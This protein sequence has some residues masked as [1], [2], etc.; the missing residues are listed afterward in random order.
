MVCNIIKVFLS[1]KWDSSK[2]GFFSTSLLPSLPSLCSKVKETQYKGALD[3]WDYFK[4]GSHELWYYN[5]A[6]A[7]ELRTNN[8]DGSYE[9]WNC[10]HELGTFNTEGSIKH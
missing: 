10:A 1:I 4:G 9:L 3:L 7:H 6:G 8:K 2:G 5:I